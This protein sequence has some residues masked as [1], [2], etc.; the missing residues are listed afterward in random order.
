MAK[1]C[2]SFAMY[3][4]RYGI[5]RSGVWYEF[6][7]FVW[8]GFYFVIVIAYCRIGCIFVLWVDVL[9]TDIMIRLLAG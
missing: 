9:F 7:W 3:A 5:Y 4:H 6:V 1:D 8:R 2:A